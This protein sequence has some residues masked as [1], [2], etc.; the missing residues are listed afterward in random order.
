MLN[1]NVL[2]WSQNK[3]N[4]SYCNSKQSADIFHS[5]TDP[6]Y[7]RPESSSFHTEQGHS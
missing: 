7:V 1:P 3:Q 4:E 2:S 5:Q 6:Y